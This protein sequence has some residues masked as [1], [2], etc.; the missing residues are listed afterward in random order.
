MITLCLTELIYLCTFDILPK[1]LLKVGPQIRS[2][3]YQSGRVNGEVTRN[4]GDEVL[5]SP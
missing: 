4:I 3:C 2:E 1:S 5:K